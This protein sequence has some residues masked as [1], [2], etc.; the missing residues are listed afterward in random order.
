M[1]VEEQVETPE[2]AKATASELKKLALHSSQYLAALAGNLLIGLIS[3]PI[4]T[5]VF[6]IAEFGLIDLAQRVILMLTVGC[7]AGLQNA[8][9]RFYDKQQFE[10]EPAA[11]RK[12]YS[13]MFLG[14]LGASAATILLFLAAVRLGA[15]PFL[16][17]PLTKLAYFIAA[18]IL[19]RALSSILWGFLR[20]EERTKAFSATTVGTRA[21]TVAVICG[22]LPWAGRT[23]Q[24]YFSGVIA[25]EAMLVTGL[26]LWL[27][28]RGL[29]TPACFN[30][31]LFRS[32]M[33]FGMPL[34]VYEFAFTILVTADRFLV[35]HFLGADALGIYSVAYGLAQQTNDLLVSPLGMAILPIYMR[36]W[37]SDGAEKTAAFLTMSLDLFLAAATGMLAIATAAARPLVVLL[38]SSKYAGAANL[39]PLLLAALLIYA[40]Y[41][42]VAAG[43]LIYKRTIQ[44]AG[45]LVAATLLNIA[46]NCL[47]L[48]YMGLPGSAVATLISYSFCIL[49]LGFAARRVLPLKLK[50]GA[51]ARY[52]L[53]A[54][55]A[56]LAGSRLELGS[57][58]VDVLARSVL[59]MTV[60]TAALYALDRRARSATRWAV[61][62]GLVLITS[63]H[64]SRSRT[65]PQ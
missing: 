65:C 25:A 32:G 30:L 56:W 49:L 9:L 1:N 61:A 35:R 19:L 2:A 36:L 14:V 44:M 48:P 33:V 58:I 3:F 17:G 28:S 57:P 16:S 51:L 5:R 50:L 59:T 23:A 40:T 43:L 62:R 29:V 22:L 24:T 26:T 38:A 47:L 18:L 52:L 13:T 46:L 4:F 12:Y 37:N 21:A 34:V 60:Y 27:L 63:F 20:I 11:A 45:I 31:S 10:A 53:A 54:L 39:I 7:K 42:F 41:I 64:L 55:T 8:V 15:G 6:S